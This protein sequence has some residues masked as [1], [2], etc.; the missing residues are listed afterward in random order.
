MARP[1]DEIELAWSSLRDSADASGWRSIPIASMSACFLRAGLSFPDISEALLA[2]FASSTVPAAEKLLAT[3]ATLAA[4]CGEPEAAARLLAA[5]VDRAGA[6]WILDAQ[7]EGQHCRA[8]EAT[9]REALG[10]AGYAAAKETGRRLSTEEA[11][12]EV[13][14]VLAVAEALD[15]PI[16]KSDRHGLTRREQEVLALLCQRLTDPEI[17]ARLFV[18]PR[19]VSSHVANM[20]A[21]L[22]AANRREAVDIA[23][24]NQLVQAPPTTVP[25]RTP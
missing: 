5:A 18:S 8:A 3:V 15:L 7:P 16:P 6:A 19:T 20:L 4:A 14:R 25:S 24:R 17:A 2:G 12:A 22:G 1:I 10:S 21:K 9:A 11:D 23:V 13:A